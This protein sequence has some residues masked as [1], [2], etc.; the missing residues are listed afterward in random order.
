MKVPFITVILLVFFIIACKQDA[1]FDIIATE[2]APTKPRIEGAPTN[3]VLFN[4]AG[5]DI[6]FVASGSLHWYKKDNSNPSGWNSF[7]YHMPQPGGK[8]ISLAVT[9]SR[10][11]A[12][13]FDDHGKYATLRYIKSGSAEWTTIGYGADYPIQSIYAD[14]EK[15]SLFVGARKSDRNSFAIYYLNEDDI[16][17]PFLDDNN[18]IL[19]TSLLSG[20]VYRE[21][22]SSFY[23]CT[24]GELFKVNETDF[25][26][27]LLSKAV[28]MGM[29]KLKDANNTII[30]V[31]RNDGY[32][33]EI[34]EDGWP[35][36]MISAN[37]RTGKYATGALGLWEDPLNPY[38]KMLIAGV[39]GGLY[40]SSSTSYSHGYVEFDLNIDS[41]FNY[42]TPRRETNSL[43]S[44]HDA[45]RYTTSLGR[46]PINHLFQAPK[47]IDGEMTFFASTQTAGLW[48]Y[49]Y[50]PD[51][52]GWQWNAE[53]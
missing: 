22:D 7:N 21:Y 46:H 20:A 26:Y 34:K 27:V 13:C 17:L 5:T 44:V 52:D 2:T 41:S 33:N 12:L 49:R 18:A 42:F 4:W 1:I 11:Y 24:R 32:L 50:R 3:M 29:I 36:R 8:I 51:N 9:A 48:S 31:E 19:T 38:R 16:L 43:Q 35:R 14:P 40:T 53:E 25:G 23:L 37:G 28:F 45:N 47:H 39:Q 6:M 30:A 15:E 10:L